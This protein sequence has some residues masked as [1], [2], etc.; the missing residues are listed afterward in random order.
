MKLLVAMDSSQSSKEVVDEVAKRPWPP[1]TTVC[2]LHVIDWPQLPSSAS[3]IEV[4]KQAAERL[5]KSA[6]ARLGNAGL[7]TTTQV[8]EG[9]P[10][11]AVADYAKEWGADFALVG[12]HGTSGLVRFLLGSVAQ[13]VLRRS[14]CSVEIVRRRARESP[15]GSSAMRILV[16]T[17][18]SE[19]SMAAV[20]SVAGRPWPAASQIRAISVVPLIVPLGETIPIGP[21]YY[22]PSEVVE[23][24]QAEARNRA[25]EAVARAYQVLSKAN[26]TP[27]KA[28]CLPTG[29]A[30]TVILDEAKAWGADL[31]VVGSHGYHGID[32]VMLGS[33]SESVA[34]HSQ[35]SVEVIREPRV[36][37]SKE[38]S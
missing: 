15:A 27:V 36:A 21:V 14:P 11:S 32:R 4:A 37:V 8:V 10:R 9:H 26:I 35:C 17:D 34:M 3:L 28:E 24:L 22:P 18:G 29:D 25:K 1:R 33:V 13:A 38:S 19:C 31:I 7:Q 12:S 30:R 16:A 23:E 6:S 5:V 2:V 20:R